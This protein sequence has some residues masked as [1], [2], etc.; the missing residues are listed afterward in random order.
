VGGGGG[1]GRDGDRVARDLERPRTG[2]G[3]AGGAAGRRGGAP[4]ARHG[5]RDP[6]VRDPTGGR[7][8]RDRDRVAGRGERNRAGAGRQ[9]ARA[10]RRVYRDARRAAG[11]VGERAAGGRLLLGPAGLRAGPCGG[12]FGGGA[13]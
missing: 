1:V 10:V 8:V 13:A 3:V 7:G 9:R 11:E 6:P 4:A 12:G 5:Q 2:G